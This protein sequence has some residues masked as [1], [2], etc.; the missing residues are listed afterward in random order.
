[1]AQVMII[2]DEEN[3]L[4]SLKRVVS[5]EGYEVKLFSS[6]IKALDSLEELRPD[7]ILLD[8]K[9]PEID[10]FEVCRRIRA[11]KNVYIKNIPIIMI[12][13]YCYEKDE[14]LSAGAD[15]FLEKPLDRAG[16]IMRI[17]RV[18]RIGKLTDE[19]ERAKAYLEE[20]KESGGKENQ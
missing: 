15:D 14:I 4:E 13:G 7:A 6:G 16:V 9:M 8:V 19:L 11:N 12:T 20:L 1:M 18:L 17:K 5:Y 2:D 3:L 10:G